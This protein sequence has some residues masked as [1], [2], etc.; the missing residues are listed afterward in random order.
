MAKP[1][2]A[3][4]ARFGGAR[5]RW[6]HLRDFWQRV[7]DGLAI[8]ELWRQFEADARA[9]YSLYSREV[10]WESLPKKS[11]FRRGVGIARLLFWALLMKLSPP[12]RVFLVIALLLTLT[13]VSGLQPFG[14]PQAV[15][16]LLAAG[17]L[18]ALLALE[19][20]DRVVMKRD[21]EIA[22]DI[23]RW[24]VPTA[25]P[26]VPGFDIAFGTR[27]ANTV[28][29]DYYDAFLREV[30]GEASK[31]L[32]VV[33]ADVAGKSVPAALLMAT[34]Q[35]SLRTLAEALP[36]L[37][38]LV[39][40][41]NHYACAHSLDG[42][43]FTT[44]FLADID[45]STGALTYINAGH[46]VP[47]LRRASGAIERLE[48]GGLPLGVRAAASY[49]C[50]AVTLEPGDLLVVYTDGV[51]EAENTQGEEYGESRLLALC[52]SSAT[53]SAADILAGLMSSVGAF[54]G[55]APQRDDLTCLIVRRSWTRMADRGIERE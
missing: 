52:Q 4:R 39:A 20:A 54:V 25:P 2:S 36:G 49:D 14:W 40:G 8:G 50:G 45:P 10:D 28:S 12:R 13:A 5:R 17:S 30:A 3:D 51:V 48:A 21:L 46:D 37:T 44:A 24:L 15:H 55:A 27:P 23:Q 11:H 47:I 33:V 16:V 29:G 34:F 31:R 42:R 18:L 41:L 43:R 38:G 19:L 35:A 26:E 9:S 32:H 7:S 22:R 6:L 53:G 1:A